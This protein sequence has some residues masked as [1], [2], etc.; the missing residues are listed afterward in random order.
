MI[1][2]MIVVLMLCC[3]LS[4][5]DSPSSEKTLGELLSLPERTVEIDSP[6]GI[7]EL[8]AELQYTQEEWA[9]GNRLV[10]RVYMSGIP[11]RWQETSEA[12]TVAK[13]KELFFRLLTPLVLHANDVIA[14]DRNRLL[15]LGTD[16]QALSAADQIWALDL[17][18]QYKII[19]AETTSLSQAHMTLLHNRV[20]IIPVSLALAQGAEES[21]WGTSRF[22]VLGNS[23][24][25]QWDFSGKGIKPERQ[26]KELGDYGLA[27]FDTPL[28]SVM[29]YMLNLNTHRAYKGLRDYRAVLR[30]QGKGVTG[31]KLATKLDKYSERGMKYVEGL[32]GIMQVNRLAATNTAHLSD[33]EIIYLVVKD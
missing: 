4:G 7:F 6:D 24:F 10:P 9:A 2:R 1:L 28:D 22:A 33:T 14:Q 29:A 26:R 18:R 21:G 17:A 3:C 25:G 23:L 20:D 31:Y 32:H 30:S 13:K 8:F 15:T 11:A 16:F 27:R 19:K 5:C 12:L